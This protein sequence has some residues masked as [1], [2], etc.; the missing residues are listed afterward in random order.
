MDYLKYITDHPRFGNY[1]SGRQLYTGDHYGYFGMQQYDYFKNG[2][3]DYLVYNYCEVLTN[4]FCNL[5][6]SE[7]PDIDL[8]S[9]K[10][11]TYLDDLIS[12]DSV[13]TT[14]RECSETAS[15]AG[16]A[17]V[18]IRTV[19][20]GTKQNVVIEQIDNQMWYPI[21]DVNCPKKAIGHII[22]YTKFVDKKEYWLLEIHT[23]GRI[24]W[25]AYSVGKDKKTL[26]DVNTVFGDEMKDVLINKAGEYTLDTGCKMPLVFHLKNN[27]IS[28]EFFGLSDYTAPLVAKI[29]AVN[30][31]LN[32]IQYVLKRHANPKMSVPSKMIRQAS[33]EVQ[34]S[35]SRAI[36]LGFG[37]AQLAK[38]MATEQGKDL[39]ATLVGER[40]LRNMEFVASDMNDKDPKYLTWDGNLNESREQI[41]NLRQSMMEESQLAKI[42]LDP[43]ANVGRAS[44]VSIMRMAQ[45]SLWKAEK[46]QAYLRQFIRQIVHSVLELAKSLKEPVE[47][48]Q[49]PTVK[50]RDGLVNDMME[51][52]TEE[53]AKLDAGIQTKQ[54][55]IARIE[56]CS[57]EQAQATIDEIKSENNILGGDTPLIQ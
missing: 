22:K 12:S 17:V 21:Y 9:E 47:E 38:S 16:D 39:F 29:F 14:L 24:E 40:L 51:L 26:I 32:Q 2:R 15:Y 33:Q 57:D 52:I 44:G 1:T 6:W 27:S 19:A 46:K 55:A 37:N 8:E 54:G 45:T 5:I 50:F 28:N 18:R 35:N 49:Y 25:Q 48:P 10:N 30:Q 11:Q 34:E 41:K 3:R 43:E 20:D 31:N 36:E 7:Q 13:M 56:G 42:L 23:I 53:T 4:A